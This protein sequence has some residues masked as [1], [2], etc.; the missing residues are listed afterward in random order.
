MVRRM[1]T[2]EGGKAGRRAGS[3][4]ERR[5]PNEN[6]IGHRRIPRSSI[7]AFQHSRFQ[8]PR[9]DARGY[10]LAA[11]MIFVTIL[12]IGLAVGFQA[13]SNRMRRDNE[14]ELIF[15]GQQYAQAIRLFQQ[16]NGRPP[17][18]LDELM[19]F[20][21]GKP[22]C[23][24][25]LWKDP[26]TP[27][28]GKWGLIFQ[29]NIRWPVVVVPGTEEEGSST[30]LPGMPPSLG[31]NPIGGM[32]SLPASDIQFKPLETSGPEGEAPVGPIIGVFSTSTKESLRMWNGRKHYCEWD[33]NMMAGQQAVPGQPGGRPPNPE[34]KGNP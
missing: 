4:A 15:R 13:W 30:T 32:G 25:H 33:F 26:M 23:I 1:A 6:S 2:P 34:G 21:P 31:Q 11:L 24:R 22:R 28:D 29:N 19:Q 12:M 8:A 3:R 17:T 5:P 14:E 18:K 16:R 20:G 9:A 10:T 27:P 7:P